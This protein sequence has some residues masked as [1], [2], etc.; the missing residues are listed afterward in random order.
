MD[1]HTQVSED[2]ADGKNADMARLEHAEN[3][4][5]N[6]R[7]EWCEPPRCEVGCGNRADRWLPMLDG[8]GE[9][10]TP[11]V[12]LACSGKSLSFY[13]GN[14]HVVD[15]RQQVRIA[16]NAL[17]SAEGLAV[18]AKAPE[19]D[20]QALGGAILLTERCV[21]MANVEPA[22]VEQALGVLRGRDATL[23]EAK[24]MVEFAARRRR[25]NQTQDGIVA[26]NDDQVCRFLRRTL[27][28]ILPNDTH[29]DAILAAVEIHEGVL[30]KRGRPKGGNRVA[31]QAE[32]N[33][34]LTILLGRESLSDDTGASA[35]ARL[36][37]HRRKPGN[38]P[39]Q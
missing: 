14:L 29:D 17:R 10:R 3:D 13:G 30:L 21:G 8:N 26:W 33:D 11:A 9:L 20:L 25:K 34:A 5:S 39:V 31:T 4:W 38:R 22:R 35:K 6:E 16:I 23:A 2:F 36:A 18:A 28:G 12:C 37:R 1:P 27:A 7:G 15:Y 19:A 32:R 24:R